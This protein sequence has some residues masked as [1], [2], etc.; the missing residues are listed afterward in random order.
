[1]VVG[2]DSG[3]TKQ[4]LGLREGA[5]ENAA[6]VGDLLAEL[7][8]RGLPND[9]GRGL[10]AV[11]DGSKVLARAVRSAFGSRVAIQRCQVHKLRNVTDHLPQTYHAEYR[12]K[13]S[14]AYAMTSS[15]DARPTLER[16]VKELERI[17]ESAASSLRGG[18]DE[19]L[20]VHR[21][22]LPASLRRCLRTTKRD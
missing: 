5:S 20:T 1:M 16:I 10:L 9:R 13:I 8:E 19:T 2:I 21:L 6:V 17:S 18:I 11:L 4:V 22:G 3:G 12:R 15:G 7:I 14:A